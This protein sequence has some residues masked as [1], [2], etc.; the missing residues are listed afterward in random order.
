M[1]LP[2]RRRRT[3]L[4]SQEGQEGRSAV[5]AASRCA[6]GLRLQRGTRGRSGDRRSRDGAWQTTTAHWLAPA[7]LFV[8][9]VPACGRPG[10]GPCPRRFARMR[11]A[12]MVSITQSSRSTRV[13]ILLRPRMVRGSELRAEGD[14]TAEVDP[15]HRRAFLNCAHPWASG[16]SG[17]DLLQDHSSRP[18]RTGRPAGRSE[19]RLCR[20]PPPAGVV[21]PELSRRA[22]GP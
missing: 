2:H 20:R 19:G 1:I 11:H 10:R 15:L 18:C 9:T 13:F 14:R 17:T 3:Q 5:G 4:K 7:R 21:R 12:A 16:A 22:G 8:R 6:Y